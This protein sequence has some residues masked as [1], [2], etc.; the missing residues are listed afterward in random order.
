MIFETLEQKKT[1]FKLYYICS[2]SQIS[3]NNK[4][5]SWW[6]SILHSGFFFCSN[7]QSDTW[8]PRDFLVL[9]LAFLLVEAS[10]PLITMFNS[11][12]CRRVFFPLVAYLY[13][14]NVLDTFYSKIK[15]LKCAFMIELK[16]QNTISCLYSVSNQNST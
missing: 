10:R 8:L 4:K 13:A 1:K 11:I 14:V 6:T 7:P 16:H 3:N 15:A 9:E 12:F 5:A 2:V